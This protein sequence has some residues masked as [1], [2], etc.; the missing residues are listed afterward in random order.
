MPA[1]TETFISKDTLEKIRGIIGCECVRCCSTD[2]KALLLKPRRGWGTGLTKNIYTLPWEEMKKY[3]PFYY[4]ICETC[5]KEEM[6]RRE[7]DIYPNSYRCKPPRKNAMNATSTTTHWSDPLFADG[8]TPT[9]DEILQLFK[10]PLLDD[11]P[12]PGEARNWKARDWENWAKE[13][14]FKNNGTAKHGDLWEHTV[15]SRIKFMIMRDGNDP[16]GSMAC[17]ADLRNNILCNSD[18]LCLEILKASREKVLKYTTIEEA[19]EPLTLTSSWGADSNT[20]N[21]DVAYT[22]TTEDLKDA[23]E[24]LRKEFGFT[25]NRLIVHKEL[26]GR[27]DD[28]VISSLEGYLAVPT[29]APLH[30]PSMTVDAVRT[31][32]A[33]ERE[34]ERAKTE[35]EK[36]ERE[37]KRAAVD[38]ERKQRKQVQPQAMKIQAAIDENNLRIQSRLEGLE[39]T[40]AFSL[41]T[42][43]KIKSAVPQPQLPEFED[44]GPIRQELEK[45]KDTILERESSMLVMSA[46][47][48]T[49]RATPITVPD[50]SSKEHLLAFAEVVKDAIEKYKTLTNPYQQIDLL[51]AL[52][53]EAEA[54]IAAKPVTTA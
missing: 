49:L 28:K 27:L 38:E 34:E 23:F 8:K 11:I 43:R 40:I 37:M 17:A 29:K 10:I 4:I 42:L 13:S 50:T 47:L 53:K 6:G 2:S 14:G 9:R 19:A 1:D 51:N 3:L 26:I 31:V 16:R 22:S 7:T 25:I 46:E 41:D 24:C 32:L 52:A 15:V 36:A 30:I 39:K 54:V 33:F 18:I 12:R 45:A 35:I 5:D 48:S 21:Y 44:P 20:K